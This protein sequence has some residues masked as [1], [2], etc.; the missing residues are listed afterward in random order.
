MYSFISLIEIYLCALNQ[1]TKVI[2][3]TNGFIRLKVSME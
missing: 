1:K 3:K 2:E